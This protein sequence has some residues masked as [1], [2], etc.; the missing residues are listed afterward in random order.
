M[1]NLQRVLLQLIEDAF[2]GIE[3]GNGVSLHEAD[4]IDSYG[5]PEKRQT[6]RAKDE[7]EDWRKLV[8][9]PEL[10]RVG[11]AGMIFFDAEGLR[12]HLPGFLSV[13]VTDP[14]GE[15]TAPFVS[16][17]MHHLTH[18]FKPERLAILSGP[19]RACI[20][21]VLKFLRKEYDIPENSWLIWELDQAIEGYWASEE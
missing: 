5:S 13:A 19:Q 15:S 17:L 1:T 20:R 2:Q 11:G 4:V 9:D 10:I 7:K 18:M 16:E 8:G 21:E 6:A 12:F 14:G 3:L